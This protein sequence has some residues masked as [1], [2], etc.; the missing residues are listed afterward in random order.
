MNEK[1][2]VIDDD[3][4]I[5][6][7]IDETLKRLDYEIDTAGDAETGIDYLEDNKYDLII[8]DIKLPGKT[9]IDLL[10]YVKNKNIDSVVILMTAYADIESAVESMKLGASN[11]FKKPFSAEEIEMVVEKELEFKRIKK[12]NESLKK[13]NSLDAIIGNTDKMNH[14]F[15]VVKNVAKSKATVLIKGE[16]GTG[17]ELFANAIYDLSD[18]RVNPFIKINC[19]ALPENLLESELFGYK[20]GA[21]TGA[22]KRKK[23]K[24]ELADKGTILLDEIGD[25][26]F[27]LQAKLLRVLQENEVNPLGAKDP[28]SI[29]VRVIATTNSNLKEKMKDGEFREDLF[30]RLNVIPIILPPLR[31]RKEDIPLLAKHFIKK[32]AIANDYSKVPDISEKVLKKLEKYDWLGNVRELENLFERV[33]V[34]GVGDKVTVEDI[35]RSD[36]TQKGYVKIDEDKEDLKSLEK[37]EKRAILK[38]LEECDGNKTKAADILGV[39]ARTL[40]NK[41]KKY[42]NSK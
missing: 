37:I 6:D 25:I 8:C 32:Y 35:K 19:A 12:E 42:N 13:K 3:M 18:R 34:L 39:T 22:N 40:R 11:Y 26:P 28:V 9:G 5:R 36:I 20:K 24:F 38:T 27:Y 4:L 1:I 21:F 41:L 23:G 7:F 15:N 31:D 16:S 29:D 17:K 30:F 33:I 10:K 14:L 2:L